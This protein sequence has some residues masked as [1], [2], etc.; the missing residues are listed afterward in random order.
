MHFLS[1]LLL[2]GHSQPS[3]NAACSKHLPGSLAPWGKLVQLADTACTPAPP[4]L[5]QGEGGL[6]EHPALVTSLLALAHSCAVYAPAQLCSSAALPLLVQLAAAAAGLREADPVSRAL[7]L[8]S[9][10][11]ATQE[12]LDEE[13]LT[14]T[15]LDAVHAV[16]ATQGEALTARLL[17]ALCDTC[18]RHLMRNAADVLRKLLGHPTLGRAA[19]GWLAAAAAS[20]QLP[21]AAGGYLTPEDCAKFAS[22]APRLAG[23]RFNALLVDFGKLARGENTSDV[24]LAYEM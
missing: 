13:G 17:A 15:H 8:L 21:G 22:L 19:A 9:R 1:A 11:A 6:R 10:L 2:W 7:E 18:P 24:L 23:P 5:A 4:S 14:Q 16:L 3:S 20:G 12:G